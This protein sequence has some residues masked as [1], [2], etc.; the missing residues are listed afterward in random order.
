MRIVNTTAEPQVLTTGTCLGNLQRVEVLRKPDD[1]GYISSANAVTRETTA[2]AASGG[3]TTVTATDGV[4]TSMEKLPNNLTAAQKQQLKEL[5]HRYDD[6]F[7]RG[8]FDMGRTSLVEH[9][10][11]TGW[12]RPVR[13]GLRRH[14]LAH[15]D[16]IDEQV[17]ELVQ[18]DIVEPAA[19]PWS[20]NVVL[21]RKKDDSYRLCVDYTEQSISY[22]LKSVPYSSERWPFLVT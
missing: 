12:Q 6:I 15:L 13:Q 19:S 7:S 1:D 8:P 17:N 16:I 18:N 21:V 9:T 10:I 14:P 11:D 5:L 20:S 22:M 4:S 2:S 3:K